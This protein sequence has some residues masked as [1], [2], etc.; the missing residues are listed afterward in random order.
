MLPN[1]E[2]RAVYDKA[3]WLYVYT[4]F[5]GTGADRAATRTHWRFGV[6]SWPQLFLADPATL[7][8]LRHTGRKTASFLAAVR[9]TR[10][11]KTR[12][13]AV[14]K[15]AAAA[16][17]RADAIETKKS[18]KLARAGLEDQDIV[19]RYVALGVLTDKKPGLVAERAGALLA[20]PNDPFRY[21]VC[22]LLGKLGR[23]E[24][25]E[26]LES[27]VHEPKNSLNPNVLRIRA[28]QALATCGDARSI[29]VIAPHATSGAIRN[30]LTGISVDALAAIA[31]RHKKAGKRV[32]TLLKRGYPQPVPAGDRMHRACVG[33]AKRIHR[34]IGDK[35][36]F[37]KVY[38]KKTRAALMR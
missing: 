25:R 29:D 34:A 11:A 27:L 14:L 23:P 38:D 17:K 9:A 6:S 20:T 10:V 32:R 1:P 13:R 12:S 18:V 21:R 28:V 5:S 3:V 24:A 35:R 36:S 15:D 31:K 30:G 22:A 19:V 33:L 16:E 7:R 26:A 8:I 37:P 4:D 2:L